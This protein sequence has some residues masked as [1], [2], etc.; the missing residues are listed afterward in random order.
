MR[1]QP[2]LKVKI[3]ERGV[4]FEIVATRGDW[5]IEGN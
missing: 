2:S 1:R 3:L 4:E 5:V